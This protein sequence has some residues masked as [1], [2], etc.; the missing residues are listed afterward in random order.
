[1]YYHF[2]I[3]QGISGI[4]KESIR[5]TAGIPCHD[6]LYPGKW[7]YTEDKIREVS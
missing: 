4:P 5:G 1:M 7:K 6:L 2:K 3:M